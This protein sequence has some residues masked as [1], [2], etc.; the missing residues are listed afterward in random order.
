MSDDQFEEFKKCATEKIQ[1]DAHAWDELVI[2]PLIEFGKWFKE[3][4]EKDPRIGHV[5]EGVAALGTA[6][7]TK[8]LARMFKISDAEILALILGAFA[9]GVGIGEAINVI[10]ECGEKLIPQHLFDSWLA[11]AAVVG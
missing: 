6:A 5:I 7:L 2:Q 11:P 8:W 9:L 10:L 3:Q 4:V 1:Y